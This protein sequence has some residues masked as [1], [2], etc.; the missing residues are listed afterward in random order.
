MKRKPM[1]PFRTL[2]F[3]AAMLMAAAATAEQKLSFDGY[4]LHYIVIPTSFLSADV[5]KRYNLVRGEGRALVNLSLLKDGV[6]VS[7]EA[8][9]GSVKNLLSQRQT[10]TFEKVVEG[11]AIYYLAQLRHSDEDTLTFELQVT[12]P[13]QSPRDLSFQQKL[14]AAG[15]NVGEHD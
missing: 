15:T 1:Q 13:G 5:A 7:A 11:E 6:G 14:Y 8:L 4:E 10:L 2:C 9:S 12:A 3:C